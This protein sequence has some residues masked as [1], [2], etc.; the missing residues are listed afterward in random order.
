M[1]FP[2][3]ISRGSYQD[4]Q[5]ASKAIGRI[6]AYVFPVSAVSEMKAARNL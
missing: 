4:Q 5:S 1:E 6:A 2:A 3:M